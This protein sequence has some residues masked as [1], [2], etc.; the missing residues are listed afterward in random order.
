VRESYLAFFEI[1]D[2]SSGFLVELSFSL[3]KERKRERERE[4]GGNLAANFQ[5]RSRAF[6]NA[7]KKKKK[8]EKKK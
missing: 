1:A 2:I 5:K 6:L 8:R 4:G 3:S 7:Q